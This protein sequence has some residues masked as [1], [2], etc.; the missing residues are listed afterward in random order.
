MSFL[1]SLW[2]A[3]QPIVS[4][5]TGEVI[6][7]EVLV[8]GPEGS[9]HAT[10]NEILR[11]S[12]RTG[13]ERLLEETCRRLAFVAGGQLAPQQK[14]FLNIDLHHKG[15]ALDPGDLDMSAA[16]VVIEVSEQQEILHDPQ[17]LDSLRRWRD[18]GYMIAL[19]DY[20]T[21]HASLGTLLTVQPDMIKIDRYIVA[22]VDEDAKRRTAVESVVRLAQ[23]LGITV[24]AEG[25]ETIGEMRALHKVGVEYVQGFLCGRPSSGPAPS[26]CALILNE[27]VLH[28]G[29]VSAS[30][31][32]AVTSLEPFYDLMLDE[33][34]DGVYYVDRTRTILR[35]SR[36]AEEITGFRADEVVGRRCM[37]R[38]L[39]H[40]D[41]NGEPLCYGMCPLVRVMADGRPRQEVV[42]LRHKQGHRERVVV[43]AVPVLGDGGRIVG[44][45][46]FFRPAPDP[47]I[48]A[49]GHSEDVPAIRKP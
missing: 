48:P 33:Y 20:G 6:G 22:H 21:G 9:G 39:D 30:S 7:H 29:R 15:M 3:F 42:S 37:N 23:D 36:A 26:P 28:A 38:I 25:V 32:S 5:T 24:I 31:T 2:M 18:Q 40:E 4:L 1:S 47:L 14:L 35:W 49:G 27:S 13:Q 43:R 19:D 46:E 17:A 16:R 8:R 44:A 10:P 11:H 45:I 34:Q 41:E 12:H